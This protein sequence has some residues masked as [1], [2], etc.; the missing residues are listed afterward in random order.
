V[1]FYFLNWTASFSYI[2][3]DS[4]SKMDAHN[5]ATVIT[6]NILYIKQKEGSANANAESGDSYFLSIESVYLMIEEQ[7]LFAEVPQEILTI[8]QHTNVQA[9]TSDITSKEIITRYEQFMKDKDAQAIEGSKN[10]H[11][12]QNSNQPSTPIIGGSDNQNGGEI[13]NDNSN[14][15]FTSSHN[16]QAAVRTSSMLGVDTIPLSGSRPGAIRVNTELAQRMA[17]NHEKYTMIRRVQSPSASITS[18]PEGGE[19]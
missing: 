14:G 15:D 19:H 8:L 3:E 4:G 10:N 7:S 12:R 5:L 16:T 1:L 18:S 13:T 11:N 17:Q 9:A 6:P 2:D